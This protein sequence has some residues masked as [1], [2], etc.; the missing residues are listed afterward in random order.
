MYTPTNF[1]IL[2]FHYFQIMEYVSLIK[3]IM[4]CFINKLVLCYDVGDHIFLASF[5]FQS[6]IRIRN[7]LTIVLDL[8]F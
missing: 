4:M 1:V 3:N 8:F 2:Y 6:E 5:Q 7:Y